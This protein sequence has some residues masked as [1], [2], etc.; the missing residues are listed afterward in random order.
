M[1]LLASQHGRTRSP[2]PLALKIHTMLSQ[3]F[4]NLS[5]GI[6]N[7]IVDK[8]LET[9]LNKIEYIWRTDLYPV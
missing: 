1:L 4:G 7:G 5:S 9:D 2:A 8:L 3:S 6:F